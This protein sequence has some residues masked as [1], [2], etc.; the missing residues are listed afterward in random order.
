MYVLLS[1]KPYFAEEIFSGNKRYEY[2]KTNFSRKQIDKVIVYA[3]SPLKSV[4]GEFEIEEI[5]CDDLF[6]LW[7]RTKKESGISKED[8]LKYFGNQSVGYAIKIKDQKRY[9]N[10]YPLEH[11]TIS[12]APQSF[13]YLGV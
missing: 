4:I 11:L 2:R 1:V 13:R 6:N 3:T 9:D 12:V 5:I 7:E 10:P 8:F